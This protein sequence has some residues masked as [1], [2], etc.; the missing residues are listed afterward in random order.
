MDCCKAIVRRVIRRDGKAAFVVATAVGRSDIDSSIT[1]SLDP[2][3]WD[4][5]GIVPL[6]GSEVEVGKLR[7][8]HVDWRAKEARFWKPCYDH[9]RRSEM[10]IQGL[11]LKL[12]VHISLKAKMAGIS[13][14]Q[15][16]KQG[17]VG[18]DLRTI[19]PVTV[20][21]GK[22]GRFPTGLNFNLPGHD[23]LGVLR[24]PLIILPRTGLA[25]EEDGFFPMAW[26]VDTGYRAQDQDGLTLA[27]RNLGTKT[28]SFQ[29]GDRVAQ[30]LLIP[31]WT[32]ELVDIAASDVDTT[33]R[34]GDRFG[35]SGM[36]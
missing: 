11:P 29:I 35:S 3:V 20:E 28:R 4:H 12:G 1:F 16:K 2:N 13:L 17:D 36:Q 8:K 34:G 10:F 24:V 22:V 32:P 15:R 23:S 30:G 25:S 33:D 14:P 5:P 27:L 31:V 7:R 9:D 21:P 18:Y 19:E 6:P 26:V